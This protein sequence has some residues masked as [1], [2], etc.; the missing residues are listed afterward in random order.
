MESYF[1]EQQPKIYSDRLQDEVECQSYSLCDT[2]EIKGS[3]RKR[4]GYRVKELLH[5][6]NKKDTCAMYIKICPTDV[7]KFLNNLKS[8][9]N[10]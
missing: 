6:K 10:L 7:G 9:T 2:K 8:L 3:L 5:R 1:K 4:T